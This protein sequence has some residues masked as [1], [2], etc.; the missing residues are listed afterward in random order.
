MSNYKWI[1][2]L[3]R[4]VGHTTA[5]CGNG[6]REHT[7]IL[8]TAQDAERV[9]REHDVPTV[10]LADMSVPGRREMG[11]VVFDAFT[12][13]HIVREYES[14]LNRLQLRLSNQRATIDAIARLTRTLHD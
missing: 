6:D 10:T 7:V 11:P 2:N 4:G 1:L 12:V 3:P 9:Q 13:Q 5:A 8:P 14:K